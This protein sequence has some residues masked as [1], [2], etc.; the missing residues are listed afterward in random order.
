MDD[1]SD[2]WNPVL[3]REVRRMLKSRAFGGTFLLMLLSCWASCLVLVANNWGVL[4][5]LERGRE[6]C[7]IYFFILLVPVCVVVPLTIFS[8]SS[9]ERLGQTLENIAMTGL[10]PGQVLNGYLCCGLMQAGLYYSALLPFISFAYL[11]R[12][13]GIAQILS[14]IF[15]TVLIGA[16]SWVWSLLMGTTV[17][18]TFSQTACL[19]FTLLGGLLA[20]AISYS[21]ISSLFSNN[22]GV[23]A[24]LGFFCIAVPTVMM[25]S[26]FYSIA[27]ERIRVTNRMARPYRVILDKQGNILRFKPDPHSLY[28]E[29]PEWH[30]QTNLEVNNSVNY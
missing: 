25:M 19:V 12:G 11:F 28:H 14:G 18:G 2:N 9:Q 24:V 5:L 4:N 26:F 23:G 1:F 13:I 27:K 3:V 15:I 21:F 8:V 30:E 20:F 10:K 17:R 22:M 16:T 6:F 29:I 7:T